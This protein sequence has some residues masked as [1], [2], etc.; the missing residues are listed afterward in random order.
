MPC[1]GVGLRILNGV[2]KRQIAILFLHLKIA[3][4]WYITQSAGKSL[5]LKIMSKMTRNEEGSDTC[6]W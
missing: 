2:K 4:Q 3:I 6:S 5:T 1:R